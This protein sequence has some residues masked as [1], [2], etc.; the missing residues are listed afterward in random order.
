MLFDKGIALY[1]EFKCEEAVKYFQQL[2]DDYSDYVDE[3]NIHE[4]LGLCHYYLKDYQIAIY[5]LSKSYK[6]PE[7]KQN[8][9]DYV[10]ILENLGRAYFGLNNYKESIKYYEE[11]TAYFHYYS[12]DNWAYKR[13]LFHLGKGRCYFHLDMYDHALNEFQAAMN[14]VLQMK[15]DSE[16]PVRIN[17]VKYEIGYTYVFLKDAKKALIHLEEVDAIKLDSLRRLLYYSY[18]GDAY[19]MLKDYKNAISIYHKFEQMAEDDDDRAGVSTKLGISYYF[20]NEKEKAKNYFKKALQYPTK[21]EWVKER[22]EKFL[23]AIE[24]EENEA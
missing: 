10:Q 11:A 2:L 12:G 18:L 4:W 15:N 8:G 7:A 20:V 21:F 24:N 3:W 23:M 16:T 13:F 14:I 6:N 5:H 22:S 17:L 19:R 9:L 1:Q